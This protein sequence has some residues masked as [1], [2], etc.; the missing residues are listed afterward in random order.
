[1]AI[2]TIPSRPTFNGL[3]LSPHLPGLSL[4]SG[5]QSS[6]NSLAEKLWLPESMAGHRR[7]F[8]PIMVLFF[9]RRGAGKTLALT[10]VMYFQARRNKVAR[11]PCHI[12]T[13]YQ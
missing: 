9:G 3:S 12:T 1:M 5:P 2:V 4:T 10:T 6:E 13:N 8:R 11:Y 7:S